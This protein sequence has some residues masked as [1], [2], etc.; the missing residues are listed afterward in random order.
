MSRTVLVYGETNTYKSSN[1]A[2]F[3]KWLFTRY[4]LPVALISSDSGWTPMQNEV[5]GGVIVPLKL[6]ACKYPIAVMKKVSAGWWPAKLDIRTGVCDELTLAEPNWS[7][8]RF[9]GYIVEGLTANADLFL[10][11]SEDKGRAIGEPLQGTEFNRDSGKFI[12]KYVEL[13]EKL[14][15]RS[16]GTYHHA[17]VVTKKYI[18]VFKS[19]PVPWVMMTAHETVGKDDN[20]RPALGPAICGTANVDKITGW[21]ECSLHTVS[22]FYQAH[23]HVLNAEGLPVHNPD[24]SVK[25]R[26]VQRE[27]AVLWYQKHPDTAI[28]TMT[29]PAKLGVPTTQHAKVLQ[30]WPDGHLWLMTDEATGV[31]EQSVATLLEAI[32]PTPNAPVKGAK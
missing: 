16:R 14:V 31:Y 27:G 17:Q 18:D 28:R 29:W 2:E 11:D 25:T 1:A 15:L 24:G 3:A 32:D 6:S 20:D 7:K 9:S 10:G 4:K 19:L 26:E 12:N 5:D 21:F 13:G 8:P 22:Q 30:R 23:V